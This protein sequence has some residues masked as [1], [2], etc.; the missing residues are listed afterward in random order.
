MQLTGLVVLKQVD[1]K[2]TRGFTLMELLVVIAIIGI[3]SSVVLA[4]LNGARQKG[5]D[6]RRISDIKKLQLALALYYDV[7]NSY[8][9]S[10][11]VANVQTALAGLVTGDFISTLPDDPSNDKDY[12]YISSAA[13]GS[14]SY[15]V[16]A[17]LEGTSNA[18]DACND[19]AGN[20]ELGAT[21][22]DSAECTYRTGP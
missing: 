6:A 4:S 19:A 22:C 5:R 13:S 3:L 21:A 2:V 15:C 18:E 17:A 14:T 10:A 9:D 16:G 7:N 11:A 1:M 20:P 12:Y 8:P